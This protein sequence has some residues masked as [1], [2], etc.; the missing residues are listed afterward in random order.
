MD[1]LVLAGFYYFHL[2][3]NLSHYIPCWFYRDSITPGHNVS[4][5]FLEPS[6]HA[7][8]IFHLLVGSGALY[9]AE[10]PGSTFGIRRASLASRRI[11]GAAGVS[12]SQSSLESEMQ[13]RRFSHRR[14]GQLGEP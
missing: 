10:L 4:H 14:R 9:L 3:K 12:E 7:D 2:L 11:M 8:G 1:L 6:K 5:F 13:K